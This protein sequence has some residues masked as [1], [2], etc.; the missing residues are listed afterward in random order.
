[1]EI[2]FSVGEPSGDQHAAHLI[3]ELQSR[4]PDIRCTGLGGPQ[5]QAAGCRLEYRLTDLAVMG[6]FRIL[7]MLAEFR[8]VLKQA[9]RYFAERKPDAVVLVDFPGFNWWVARRAK[10]AGI[11]V[12]Y[13]VPPQ[14]WAWASWRVER[15]RKFVDRVLCSLPFEPDWYAERGIDVD[16]VGHP[17]FDEVAEKALDEDFCTKQRQAGT[18]IVAILPGSRGHEVHQNFPDMLHLMGRWRQRH[19]AVRF[20]VANY[21]ESHR[22]LCIELT[23]QFGKSLPIEFHVN[24]TSEIIELAKCCLM[25]SGSVSLELLARS[26]PAVVTYRCSAVTA[27]LA[28][29][30]VSVKYISLPNLFVDREVFPEFYH[31]GRSDAKLREIETIVSNWIDEPALLDRKRRELEAMQSRFALRGATRK[32]ADCILTRLAAGNLR[33]AA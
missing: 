15:V 7:P 25:V 1:M 18:R 4:S 30:L 26:T 17:F 5:M 6:F 14:I 29:R 3:R 20:L 31:V 21:K 11:P 27:W 9:D 19:P 16:Y 8:R 22:D 13:Y 12:F 32:A 23:R 33:R 24:R 10:A 28:K 2:F